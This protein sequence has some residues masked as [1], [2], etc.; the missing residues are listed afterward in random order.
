MV[1]Q[2]LIEYRRELVIA[3][4]DQEPEPGGLLA[5]VHEQVTGLLSVPVGCAV[6]PRT[7]T[8]RVWISITKNMYKRLR[9]TVSTCRKSHAGSPMPGTPGTAARSG[10]SGGVRV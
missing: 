6:T 10:I 5:E 2:H 3:I 9:K 7:W 4:T 8:R 1:G